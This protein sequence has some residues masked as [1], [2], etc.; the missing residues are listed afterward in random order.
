[1]NSALPWRFEL[2]A[3][4]ASWS[5]LLPGKTTIPTF[6]W[7]LDFSLAMDVGA[8]AGKWPW[9]GAGGIWGG[10]D[11]DPESQLHLIVCM[12]LGGKMGLLLQ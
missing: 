7:G 10:T 11:W 12:G 3:Y 2:M 8:A 1:M 9:L 5:Q 4:H 6:I